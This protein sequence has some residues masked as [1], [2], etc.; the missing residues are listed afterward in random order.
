MTHIGVDAAGAGA[1]SAS[2]SGEA[3][4]NAFADSAQLE[5]DVPLRCARLRQYRM[6]DGTHRRR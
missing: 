1:D 3:C 2:K 5:P 4:R 6:V